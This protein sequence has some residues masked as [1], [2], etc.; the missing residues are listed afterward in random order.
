MAVYSLFSVGIW[1]VNRE[2]SLR[3]VNQA[4]TYTRLAANVQRVLRR[5]IGD[6]RSSADNRNPVD[7]EQQATCQM[8]RLLRSSFDAPVNW[9]H[10]WPKLSL[11]LKRKPV[12]WVVE[13]VHGSMSARYP[14]REP[15][16]HAQAHQHQAG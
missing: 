1:S 16:L 5:I 14:Q 6:M 13:F 7:A 4:D 12:A 15:D 8:F 3:Y 11:R 9:S 2:L 10:R